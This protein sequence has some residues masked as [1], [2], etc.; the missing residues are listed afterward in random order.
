[1][2]KLTSEGFVTKAIAVHDQKYRYEKAYILVR[3]SRLLLSVQN[4]VNLSKLLMAICKV[5]DVQSVADVHNNGGSGCPKCVSSISYISS[6]WLDSLGVP[7]DK[8]HREVTK[9]IPGRK[10]RVDGFI[11]E[12]NTVYEFYGDDVHG[13][14]RLYNLDDK[15]RFGITYRDA[16]Q[17]TVDREKIFKEAGFGLVTIWESDFRRQLLQEFAMRTA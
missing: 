17:K 16:Y 15:N 11:P 4:M 2:R 1:M 14:P 6:R 8:K 9:L 10:F 5:V 13:N 7:D 3:V 12:T